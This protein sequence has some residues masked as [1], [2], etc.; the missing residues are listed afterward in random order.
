MIQIIINYN[1]KNFNFTNKN[2]NRVNKFI[3]SI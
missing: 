1:V 2:E 3:S